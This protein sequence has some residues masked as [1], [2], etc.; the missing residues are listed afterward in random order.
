MLDIFELRPYLVKTH[1][2]THGAPGLD[3]PL[4]DLVLHL[5]LHVRS[6]G[7]LQSLLHC[8]Q[9]LSDHIIASGHNRHR[10]VSL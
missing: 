2:H 1:T 3:K 5:F 6:L 4:S 8:V 7:L 10:V 9:S